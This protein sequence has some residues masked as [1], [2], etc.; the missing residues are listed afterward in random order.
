M[1][2]ESEEKVEKCSQNFDFYFQIVENVLLNSFEKN[3]ILE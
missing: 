3:L 1:Y 2:T